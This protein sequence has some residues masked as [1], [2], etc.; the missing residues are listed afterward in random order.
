MVNSRTLAARILADV[1]DRGTPLDR[2]L[3]AHENTLPARDQAFVQELCYGVLRWLPRLRYQLGQLLQKPLKTGDR[4]IECLLLIGLYQILCLD[5]PDHAAVSACVD[6]SRELKKDWAEKLVNAVLRRAVRECG[7]LEKSV[8]NVP[9]AYYAHPKWLL[10]RL[11]QDWPDDWQQIVNAN[12]QRP[13][14]C[15]RVN[16]RRVSRDDYAERLRSA[17]FESAPHAFAPAALTVTPA[18]AVARLPGF[19]EGLVSVQDAAAQLAAGLLDLQ[20]RLRVLDAC[21]APGG[22]T[23]HILESQPQLSEVVA[24]ESSADRLQRMRSGLDRL[25]LQAML[26]HADARRPESWWDK[27]PFDRILLDAPCTGTGVIRRHPD[28]KYHRSVQAVEAAVA[29]QNELLEALWPLL[30]AGGRLL[31]ATC[32][33]LPAENRNMISGFLASHPDAEALSIDARWG[34]AAGAGRQILPGDT[35]MDGFFYA[36]LSKH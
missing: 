29:L 1:L 30:R 10:K 7:T 19:S 3:A 28:I 4:D 36:C 12:N 26:V 24:V 21:A 32:S 6:S 14:F 33:V 16:T 11:Q 22:K 34:R 9:A 8:D 27:Q 31:Y 23:A 5:T 20:P 25:Q 2:A 13:P 18:A 35:D 17:G 15:I